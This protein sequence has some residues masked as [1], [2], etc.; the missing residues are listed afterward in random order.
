M[1]VWEYHSIVIVAER[2]DQG[3]Q[4]ALD[5]YGEKGWELVSLTPEQS[6][7]DARFGGWNWNTTSYRATFKRPTA[8]D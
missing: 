1:A 5:S 7:I 8:Q 4:A 3:F 2:N 6:H